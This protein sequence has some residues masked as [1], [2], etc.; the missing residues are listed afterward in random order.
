M[1]FSRAARDSASSTLPQALPMAQAPKLISETFQPVRPSVRSR[2]TSKVPRLEATRPTVGLARRSRE[3]VFVRA[4]AV[5]RG[6]RHIQ[7]AQVDGELAAVVVEM[8]EQ[9]PAVKAYARNGHDGLATH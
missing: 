7:Q 2:M 9:Y 4:G 5:D 8:V 1:A 6:H 3:R